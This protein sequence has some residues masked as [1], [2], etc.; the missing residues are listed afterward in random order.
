MTKAEIRDALDDLGIEYPISGAGSLK[1]DLEKLLP[2]PG[3]TFLG[4]STVTLSEDGAVLSDVFV[5]AD[6]LTAAN[7]AFYKTINGYGW[8]VDVDGVPTEK[9][10]RCRHSGAAFTNEE[11]RAKAEARRLTS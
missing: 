10:F 1:A 9:R 6:P 7:F 11:A 3:E 4:T 2:Q 5:A 8:V